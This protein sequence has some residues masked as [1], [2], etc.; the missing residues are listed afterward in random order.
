MRK[1]LNTDSNNSLSPV[2]SDQGQFMRGFFPENQLQSISDLLHNYKEQ[3]P[4][5]SKKVEIVHHVQ[6]DF[7]RI[8]KLIQEYFQFA[9]IV[10]QGNQVY[11]GNANV[12]GMKLENEFDFMNRWIILTKSRSRLRDDNDKICKS[13]YYYI[14]LSM[15]RNKFF[16]TLVDLSNECL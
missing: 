2:R 15:M 6:I 12:H 9:P 8:I 7:N 5:L 14:E 13:K 3:H 4:D 1:M 11:K 10:M 16:F